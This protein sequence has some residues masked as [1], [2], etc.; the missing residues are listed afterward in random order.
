[1]QQLEPKSSKSLQSGLLTEGSV[2][3]FR[4]PVDACT[5]SINF[6]FD[7]IGAATL[8]K[9]LTRL[10]DQLTGNLLGLYEFR[11]SGSGTNN[12]IIAVNGTAAYYLSGSTWTSK[13]AGLTAGSKARFST[14]LDYVF[15]VN[16]T[17]ATAIWD[18]AT[19]NNF[20][21]TGNAASA[22]T[23]KYIENYRS[24][25]WIAGNSTYPDRLYFSSLPS[26]V[27]T[28]VITWN[29]DVNTGNWIDISPSDGENITA[30]KRSKNSLLVFKNNHIYRV[31]SVSETEPDPKINV[32]TY[33]QESVIETKAGIFFHHPT[34]FYKYVDGEPQEISK[35][36]QDIVDNITAA[37]YTKIAG[38]DDGDHCYWSVG[39]V[40]TNG[41]T[42]SN[43][44]V[45]Y[46]IS[47][48]TWTHRI[49]PTQ[50][51]C[52]SDYNDGT[53][54]FRLVG[55]DDGNVHKVNIGN[56]DNGTP[57]DYSLVTRWDNL[58]GSSSTRKSVMKMM[59]VH[60]EGA[61]AN[62]SYQIENPVANEWN[63]LVQLKEVDTGINTANIKGRKMRF[64]LSG[65]SKGEPFDFYGY[66]ILEASS[67]QITFT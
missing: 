28:P 14:F 30:L 10:G 52:S 17:E 6:D 29:T 3:E 38:W 48:Q 67:E 21:T 55:D 43:L 1:M 46:T 36:I 9:G 40:T 18:G 13:R 4:V 26:S 45:R 8:R 32:G 59:F 34:G 39:D 42:Y 57:I 2:S 22:P 63:P 25:V 23:G 64:R 62:V 44:V 53:S 7:K 66:E 65:T 41:V 16:G 12:Q 5:E 31:Y 61:G 49:Y 15:M 37:N 60:N 19:G 56:D 54:L 33:S 58:D 47:S 35:P 11:D 24:R 27:T 20:L 50:F 51:L